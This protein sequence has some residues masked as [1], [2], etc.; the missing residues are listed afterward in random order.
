MSAPALTRLV[1]RRLVRPRALA[2]WACGIA[3]GLG[4]WALLT[5]WWD[6]DLDGVGLGLVAAALVMAL[7]GT[8]AVLLASDV[9]RLALA[10]GVTRRR[11]LATW[12]LLSVPVLVPVVA[13]VVAGVSLVGG[14][15][16]WIAG[17]LVPLV[18]VA[19]TVWFGGL[20]ILCALASR[21]RAVR[22]L[23]APGL[24]LVALAS[25]VGAA[26]TV[27]DP[28][29]GWLMLAVALL[30][31]LTLGTRLALSSPVPSDIAGLLAR[32]PTSTRK[33]AR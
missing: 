6:Q 13:V 26:A 22:R 28:V 17:G 32:S 21:R 20:G 30:L 3:G 8:I 10:A 2:P 31:T 7:T 19:I 15:R 12:A 14:S 29:P 1:L 5:L 23:A 33:V 9:V 11:V 18:L 27:F 24:F 4:G 16:G 25:V